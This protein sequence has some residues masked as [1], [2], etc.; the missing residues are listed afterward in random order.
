[1]TDSVWDR[2][3]LFDFIELYKSHPCLWR[4]DR[5][6]MFYNKVEKQ[7]AYMELVDLIKDDFPNSDIKFVKTKIKNIRNSFRREYNKVKKSQNISGGIIY[8]PN[9]W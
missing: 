1:M 4:I 6:A 8:V 5:E 2:A 7:R 3:L 9:L